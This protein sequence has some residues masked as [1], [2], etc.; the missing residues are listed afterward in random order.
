MALHVNHKKQQDVVVVHIRSTTSSVEPR[1][2]VQTALDIEW[3]LGGRL[4]I[5]CS[6][7]SI[8]LLELDEWGRRKVAGANPPTTQG[9][10]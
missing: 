7:N 10:L 4:D 2:L 5:V 1:L 8:I 3:L 6:A 9:T